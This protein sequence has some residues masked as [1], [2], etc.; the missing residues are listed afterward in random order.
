M[1][2]CLIL[3]AILSPLA[4][5]FSE[6]TATRWWAHELNFESLPTDQ[7]PAWEH[8]GKGGLPSLEDGK[9]ILTT[10][11]ETQSIAYVLAEDHPGDALTVE[12]RVRARDV[13]G[14]FAAQFN[15]ILIGKVYVLP[16]TNPEEITFRMV[17]E[18]DVMMLY[19]DGASAE[20]IKPSPD[21]R[22]KENLQGQLLF[23]DASSF[24][25][26]TTE[27]SELRWAWGKAVHP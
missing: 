21:V 16:I 19:R 11:N 20:E 25:M 24:A 10:Q 14:R 17:L 4:S 13:L 6:E 8:R 22:N 7:T 27:W 12:F 9:L 2:H 3:L 5:A 23:G 18:N 15:V 26:G 1:K